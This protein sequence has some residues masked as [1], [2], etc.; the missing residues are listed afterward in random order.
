MFSYS[1]IPKWRDLFKILSFTSTKINVKIK[2]NW[3][4]HNKNI[5]NLFSK[6]SW[7]LFLIV[8]LK[9][10]KEPINIWIPS[11]YCEDGIYLIKKLNVNI[12]Y[13]EIDKNFIPEKS[14]LQKLSQK[15]RPDIIIY[16]HFFGKNCFNPYLK[17]IS[18]A[19]NSWLIEDATHCI[20]PEND[21]GKYGDFT[22]FSPYKFLPTP[23][24][25]ILATSLKFIEDNKLEIL[26]DEKKQIIF[27]SNYFNFLKFTKKNN[28]LTNFLWVIKKIINKFFLNYLN[29]KDFDYDPKV[30]NVNFF[31]H[32]KI[33]YFSKNL[34]SSYSD[35]L[36]NEKEKR[37]RML[38]LWKKLINSYDELNDLELDMSFLENKQTPYFAILQQPKLKLLEKYNLL[39]KKKLPVL[40]W[41]NLSTDIP[42]L[43][44]AKT[45]RKNLFFL[46]LNNQPIEIIKLLKKNSLK[47]GQ[48]N[49]KDIS[50]T[51]I[52]N[53]G[54]W[55]NYYNLISFSNI[56]QSWAYG[57][58][59]K[60]SLNLSVKRYLISI[61]NSP[62]GIVQVLSK[63]L[64]FFNYNRINRGPLFFD[65]LNDLDQKN[66]ILKLFNKFNN[67]K[68][69][70]FLSYS[71]EIQFNENNILFNYINDIF[72]FNCPTW[73]S[74]TI[75][76]LN[77]EENLKSKLD[78]KW[79]NLLN[80]SQR[81]KLL[82]K[83]ESNL[84][85]LN[86][87]IDLNI[88]D[89]K[90]KNYK[91]VNSTLLKTYLSNSKFI[92]LNA[93]HKD[94]LI[95]SICISIHGTTATYLIGWS[96]DMGREK[97]SM[98]LLLWNSIIYLKKYGYKFYD[99]G[100]LD[101]S[102]SYGIYKFKNDIG[103][104]KY[105]LVGNYNFLSKFRLY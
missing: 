22:I 45:L 17:D 94:K 104:K 66:I 89:Q 33:D 86:K 23:T 73:K 21:I 7:S 14:N 90:K 59:Q 71:P 83:E 58:A 67:L 57:E 29:I 74:S 81:E 12:H 92:I 24:G 64:I 93:Y 88:L 103:G 10:K 41:P 9:L 62:K 50:L 18:A 56:S 11:Y 65:G 3:S 15:H 6:S 31:S 82:V 80:A 4:S 60:K 48:N 68:N 75:D 2:K 39:K 63:K 40:T 52:N 51:E 19:S 49:L 25:A 43:S 85:Q 8:A 61:N 96:D 34:I 36:E 28:I 70:N 27:L 26:L 98:N 76:L 78:S 54:D 16:C 1:N 69:F 91:G 35:R 100:G 79:R 32:P 72:Y 44:D 105:Q 37:V 53:Q 84:F 97:R 102:V 77:T 46:P 5:I 47:L 99:L 87:L 101:R 20:F 42:E 38:I 95:S 13:Y 55:E 30:K